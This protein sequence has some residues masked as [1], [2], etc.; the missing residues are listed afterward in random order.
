MGHHGIQ[1]ADQEKRHD[2]QEQGEYHDHLA[3][4]MPAAQI[5]VHLQRA[6]HASD[7]EKNTSPAVLGIPSPAIPKSS[8]GR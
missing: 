6:F 8:G 1:D 5:H 3:S 2:R 7:L 4:L